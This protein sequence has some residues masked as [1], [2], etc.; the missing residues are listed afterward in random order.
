MSTPL[1]GHYDLGPAAAKYLEIREKIS[2]ALGVGGQ[3]GYALGLR[4]FK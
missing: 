3:Q 4:V 1:D 2:T